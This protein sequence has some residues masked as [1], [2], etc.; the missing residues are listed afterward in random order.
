MRR[1][2]G[3]LIKSLENAI[4][5]GAINDYL[6]SLPHTGKPRI[7]V[8]FS[9]GETS[10]YM[11]Y[12]MKTEMSDDYELCF[13]MANTGE[14]TEKSL[15]FADRCDKAWGLNLIYV[16]AVV[17]PEFGVASTHKQVTFETA[18]RNGEPFEEMIKVYGIPNM[19]F[20]PCNRE[21]KLNAMKSYMKSISWYDYQ[22]AIGIRMDE[23]R[24]V[25][26]ETAK[27]NKIIYPLIDIWPTDKQ[28]VRDFWEDQPFQLGLQEH[29]GNCKW[30][31][32]KSDKKHFRLIS[33]HPEIYDFPRR[34]EQQYGW[35][36]APHYGEPSVDGKPRVFFRNKRSTDDMFAQA[37]EL[38]FVPHIP[39]KEVRS[40]EARQFNL[41][42][43]AGGCGE[44]C[45]PYPMEVKP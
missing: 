20:E 7:K 41:D 31:W 30:C 36:G 37:R 17:H 44:T 22:T 18:S 32:K 11:A 13:V 24:R 39:I 28:D 2:L 5:D 16:E 42:L 29:E 26:P 38:G 23:R 40:H 12:R 9:S 10:A 19:D 34:M 6:A 4:Y 21:L 43:D 1:N 14:E 15:I 33:E 8:S 25:N 35:C 27:K 45:E 3:N